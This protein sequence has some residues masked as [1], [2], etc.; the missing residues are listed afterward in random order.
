MFHVG[1]INSERNWIKKEHQ[2]NTHD[3]DDK[4]LVRQTMI[5]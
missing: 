4:D 3:L 5:R 1:R 2:D